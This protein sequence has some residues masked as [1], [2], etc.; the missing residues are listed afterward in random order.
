MK[1]FIIFLQANFDVR[2]REVW[3]AGKVIPGRAGHI[4]YWSSVVADG[5]HRQR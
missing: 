1:I 2:R 5:I 4:L 3:W